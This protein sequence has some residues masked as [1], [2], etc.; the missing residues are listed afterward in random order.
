MTIQGVSFMGK[1]TNLGK[2]IFTE[3]EKSHEYLGTGTYIKE[4]MPE[5][6]DSG[7]KALEEQT[8]ALNDAIRAK[9]APHIISDSSAAKEAAKKRGNEWA[10]AHG[11]PAV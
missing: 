10:I 9:Y 6:I 2:K 7:K 11:N 3:A 1:S 5:V 8:A 4:K